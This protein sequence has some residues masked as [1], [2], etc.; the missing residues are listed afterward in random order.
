MYLV[1]EFEGEYNPEVDIHSGKVVGV[2]DTQGKAVETLGLTYSV[3]GISNDWG[4][5]LLHIKGNGKFWII[6]YMRL[7]QIGPQEMHRARL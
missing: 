4:G 1:Y 3:S 7:N 2:M 5:T 6:R